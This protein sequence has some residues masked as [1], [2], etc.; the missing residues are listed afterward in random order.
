[1][2][3]GPLRR[4]AEP[5]PDG[6]PRA[7][8]GHLQ[9]GAEQCVSSPIE[10]GAPCDTGDACTAGAV[11]SSQ[12]CT[13]GG[14][15]TAS[16][17]EAFATGGP[18]WTLGEEWQIGMAMQSAGFGDDNGDPGFDDTGEGMLA[19]ADIGGLVDVSRTHAL[20]YLT[21]PAVSTGS[22]GRSSRT[23]YRWLNSDYQ[24]Y[25]QDTIEVSSDGGATWTVVWENPEGVPINDA[26]WT[27][28][29]IDVTAY[30]G[31]TTTVRWGFAVESTLAYA[32]SGWNID[33]VKLQ[34]A[35]CPM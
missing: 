17:T 24:P 33:D 9:R 34:D 3:H 12:A 26:A 19:G 5:L 7:S 1:M 10:D 22:P 31:P 8:G 18:G 21:S 16:F 25:M 30:K 2:R 15:P 14:A 29:S 13:G 11:C 20:Y 28:Q 32:E 23:P 27:F 35:P 6:Q 4:H